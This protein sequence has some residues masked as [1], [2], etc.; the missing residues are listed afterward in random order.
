[1][2]AVKNGEVHSVYHGGART[3][4]DYAFLQYIAKRL[5]P[6]AFKDVDPL[7][8]LTGFYER[9]LPIKAEGTFMVQATD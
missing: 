4:Y 3:L 1:L 8:S 9:Y 7:A 5:H 2:N 6:D